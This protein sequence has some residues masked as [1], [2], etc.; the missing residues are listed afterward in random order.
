ML[1]RRSETFLSSLSSNYTDAVDASDSAENEQPIP[2]TGLL[3][4]A[5]YY[6]GSPDYYATDENW[7]AHNSGQWMYCL[8]DSSYYHVESDSYYHH[9]PDTG[10]F[11]ETP[12]VQPAAEQEI[13]ASSER[14]GF[15]VPPIQQ[16]PESLESAQNVFEQYG[17][18]ASLSYFPTDD[19]SL[20]QVIFFFHKRSK[21]DFPTPLMY[22]NPLSLV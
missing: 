13:N 21:C 11:Y 18:Q 19:Q 5:L 2:A 16:Q 6:E 14:E 10:Y 1:P 20:E 22:S 3:F 15:L 17:S 7:M 8:V 9:D 4:P 12:A